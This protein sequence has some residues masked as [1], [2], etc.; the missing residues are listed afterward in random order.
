MYDYEIRNVLHAYYD[1]TTIKFMEHCDDIEITN[2]RRKSFAE[3]VY[4][5]QQW[6]W[7]L[8]S[9]CD[10]NI[11]ILRVNAMLS[12]SELEKVGKTIVIL[13]NNWEKQK[14]MIPLIK[15]LNEGKT[16]EASFAKLCKKLNSGERD[17]C[18]IYKNMPDEQAKNI[19]RVY[20]MLD[21]LKVKIRQGI[22]NWNITGIRRES[23]A[24]HVYST[25]Q[26]A[27]LMWV[28][29][30]EDIDIFRILAMLS[31]HETEEIIIGDITP[32]SG[33]SPEE[34]LRMG[35]E[36]VEKILHGLRQYVKMHSFIKEFDA[37]KTSDAFFAHLCDKLDC[38][39]AVKFYSD[40]GY[41]SIENATLGMKENS[42]IQKFISNGAKTVADVFIMADE[43]MYV[44]TIFK[45]IVDF[46]K[47]YN[48]STM[49]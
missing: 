3:D 32:Y 21:T 16:L 24:E 11:D 48:V 44:N 2:H 19:E 17:I 27:W 13:F 41:C 39:L 12:L 25:Q 46:V 22:I 28:V 45:E 4:G 38:D 49:S 36:A 31:I 29:S 5:A 9:E 20:N 34:K 47:D 1:M 43:H 42:E 7:L 23:I 35:N 10:L 6:A 26:L 18:D 15:E 37:E 30:K 33:I 8:W 40:G 14:I